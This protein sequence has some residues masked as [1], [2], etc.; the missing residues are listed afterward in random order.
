MARSLDP[1]SSI[2]GRSLPRGHPARTGGNP[3][4]VGTSPALVPLLPDFCR[5]PGVLQAAATL[6]RRDARTSSR[7]AARAHPFPDRVTSSVA[8]SAAARAASPWAR[9]EP[10]G[11]APATPALR[12]LTS[13][14][15]GVTRR[16]LSGPR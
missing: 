1:G 6:L 11:S 2:D 10:Y 4:G 8:C 15:V 5:I 14:G 12:T 13:R 9:L 16:S 3:D 7:A